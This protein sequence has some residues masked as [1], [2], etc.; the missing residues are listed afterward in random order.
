VRIRPPTTPATHAEES[1]ELFVAQSGHTSARVHL[2]D[3]TTRHLHSTIHP[4]TES[5]HFSDLRLW[6]DVIIFAGTGL[7]CHL[8]NALR[9]APRSAVL[10]LVEYHPE[11]L[12]QCL[13]DTFGSAAN[14]KVALF[15]DTVDARV[16]EVRPPAGVDSPTVQ[17]VKHPASY[18]LHADFYES[19]VRRVLSSIAPTP[20][21][22]PAR[23][24][25]GTVLLYG[26]FFL[27]EECRR[28][29]S[30]ATGEEPFL[31]RYEEMPSNIAYESALEQALQHTRPRC[32]L[33]I[34]MKGFD[35]NGALATI[36]RRLGIP[37]IVWFVDDPH[38]ILLHQKTW[39][40]DH[41]IAA[42]WERTF[43][44]HLRA[45]GFAHAF[46]LPLAT[47]PGIMGLGT[48]RQN[49]TVPL[50]FVGSSMGERFLDD[51]RRKFLWSSALSPIVERVSDG[52]LAGGDLP[53][54]ANIAD[55]AKLLGV[56]MPFSDP[57]N[58][59]WLRSLCIH[60]ASKKR[61]KAIVGGLVDAGIQTFGDP[62]GWRSL[63]GSRIATHPD[64]DYATGIADVYRSIAVNVNITSCQMKTAVNQRVFDVPAAGSF[65][66]SDSR[67]DLGEFFELGTEAVAYGSLD[68]LRELIARYRDDAPARQQIVD[69]ARVRIAREHTYVQ[70]VRRMVEKLGAVR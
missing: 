41:M 50:G 20:G 59:A 21:N 6:G 22:H 31:F 33:S 17:V 67:A 42:C 57:R 58:T 46:H 51:I 15:A 3:G 32:V 65:V 52:I 5:S 69:A 18:A 11:L 9:T 62:D 30:E 38:P 8:T 1:V 2:A 48:P 47:D 37:V 61:R 45:C 64:I 68:E 70:R 16:H 10:V 63:C 4:E 26:R 25:G 55:V 60:T 39:V 43:L 19:V 36:T 29:L 23:R 28:A 53:T 54:V 27:Q 24:P 56:K 14:T 12:T 44:P 49:A 7:G 66:L 40:A 35:G 34:N 13:V